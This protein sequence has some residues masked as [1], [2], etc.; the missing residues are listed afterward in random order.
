LSENPLWLSCVGSALTRPLLA[1]WL[2]TWLTL[3]S[4]GLGGLNVSIVNSWASR[5]LRG[6]FRSVINRILEYSSPFQGP[7]ND[8]AS[9]RLLRTVFFFLA[10]LMPLSVSLYSIITSLSVNPLPAS[11]VPSGYSRALAVGI[12]SMANK[13]P[14]F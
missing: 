2:N 6:L 9:P 13:T 14:L 5:D 11:V 7:P 12:N 4:L 8:A 10:S 3:A 1:R